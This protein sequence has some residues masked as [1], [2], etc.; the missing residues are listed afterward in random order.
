MRLTAA[1]FVALASLVPC[2][3]AQEEVTFPSAPG[4]RFPAKEDVQGVLDLPAGSSGKVPAVIVIH[5]SGGYD[6]QHNELYAAPLRAAGIATFG[7]VMHRARSSQLPSYFIPHVFGAFKY[8]VAHP[9]IDPARIGVMGMSL[10][11]ILSIYAASELLSA[12]HLGTGRFSAHA[13]LYPVCWIHEAIASGQLPARSA[14]AFRDVYARLTGAPVKI[15]AG[16]KDED[17]EPDSCQNFL[18]AL[19]PEARKTVDLVMFPGATHAWDQ[20]RT[21]QLYEQVANKGKGKTI[22]I[23]YDPTAT[24]KGREAVVEFFAK[25]LGASR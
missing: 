10:G 9:R 19:S 12:E 24:A 20:G 14:A 3:Q 15:L 2:A 6:R 17:D 8:L 21:F 11:G 25:R 16:E 18:A 23:V 1:V 5:T 22:S 7:L 13:A 4:A